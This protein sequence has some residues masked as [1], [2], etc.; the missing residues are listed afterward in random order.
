MR[1]LAKLMV[2]SLVMASTGALAVDQVTFAK[3]SPPSMQG[4]VSP[5]TNNSNINVRDKS[6]VTPTAQKQSN[7]TED[8]KLLAEVR[9]TVVRDKR[10]SRSAH[11]VKI[12]VA[13]GVVTLRGPVKSDGEKSAIEKLAK[14]VAGVSSVNNQLDIK[15]H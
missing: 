14:Q 6:G 8:R 3:G 5:N 9:H 15:T 12:M 13:N 11:N 2:L 4:Q 1:N 10:L 7:A